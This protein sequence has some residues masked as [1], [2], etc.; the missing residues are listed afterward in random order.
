M[1]FVNLPT[2]SYPISLTFTNFLHYPRIKSVL[3]YKVDITGPSSNF[4]VCMSLT[5][6]Y[7]NFLI[8]YEWITPTSGGFFYYYL[9]FIRM[10]YIFLLQ[11]P[12]HLEVTQ[13]KTGRWETESWSPMCMQ[14]LLSARWTSSGGWNQSRYRSQTQ[15][16]ELWGCPKQHLVLLAQ[17]AALQETKGNYTGGSL[18]KLMPLDVVNTSNTEAIGYRD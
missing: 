1:H 6:L 14:S 3:V 18:S 13:A 7:L 2:S 4:S 12:K 5:F 11:C 15:A 16:L 10:L 8:W 17:T 9:N